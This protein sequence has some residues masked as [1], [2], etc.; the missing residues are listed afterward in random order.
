[1]I[2]DWIGLGR[3]Q[4]AISPNM[5]SVKGGAVY[6]CAM[7]SPYVPPPGLIYAA[8]AHYTAIMAIIDDEK[9][10]SSEPTR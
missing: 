8:T 10:G 7:S 2:D 4:I 5:D 6:Q 3:H 9:S 1:M